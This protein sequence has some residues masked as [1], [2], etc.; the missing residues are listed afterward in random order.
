MSAHKSVGGRLARPPAI[1]GW[2]YLATMPYMAGHH[3]AVWRR[4]IE[5]LT[6]HITD[7]IQYPLIEWVRR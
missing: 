6:Y 3:P 1:P 7:R 2:S 4:L 5:P